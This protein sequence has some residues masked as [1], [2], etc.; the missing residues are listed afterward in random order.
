MIMPKLH[1]AKPMACGLLIDGK[2][3]ATVSIQW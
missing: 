3:M 2:R 1:S